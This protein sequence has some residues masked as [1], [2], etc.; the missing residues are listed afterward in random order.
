MRSPEVTKKK[1]LQGSVVY[2]LQLWDCTGWEQ[3]AVLDPASPASTLPAFAS[4]FPAWLL[5][6]SSH[7]FVCDWL[8]KSVNSV[9]EG[10]CL[11]RIHFLQAFF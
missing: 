7:L 3:A 1:K 9:H 11:P 2:L 8:C 4:V 5:N 10:N 6:I